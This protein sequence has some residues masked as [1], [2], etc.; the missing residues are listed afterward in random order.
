MD[1]LSNDEMSRYEPTSR[2]SS[3]GN[4]SSGGNASEST[5]AYDVLEKSIF[6]LVMANDEQSSRV[7]E[8]LGENGL[9]PTSVTPV[10][11]RQ[12]VH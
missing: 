6:E 8:S 1:R 3:L 11:K 9:R 5:E 4:W 2:M 7:F 12:F 10:H